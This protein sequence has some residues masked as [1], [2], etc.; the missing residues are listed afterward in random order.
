MAAMQHNTQ[1]SGD[2]TEDD[3]RN[4]QATGANQSWFSYTLL[5]INFDN[6]KIGKKIIKSP[7][8]DSGP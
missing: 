1:R 4:E 8:S 2:G 3:S 5:E 7:L 6:T